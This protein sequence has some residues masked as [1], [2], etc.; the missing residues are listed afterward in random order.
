[1]TGLG[2][3]E[4][5]VVLM[6]E[7][8]SFDSMLGKLYPKSPA[9]DGLDGGESNRDATGNIIRVA[10]RPGTDP[11]AMSVPNP[12]PG[13]LWTDIN[14]QLF[15]NAVVPA[16]LPVAGMS[17][18]VQNYMAQEDVA[19]G[20]YDPN[21]V[22]NYYTPEQVPVIS[23]LARQFAVCDRWFASAPC[24]T[25]P[26]RFFAHTGTANGFENNDP[27]HFP[28]HMDTI[29]NRL[30]EAGME[31]PWKIYY[32]DYAQ[33]WSL[34]KLWLLM[35]HFHFYEQFQSDAKNGALPAYAFI[36]PRYYPHASQLP[37]DQHPPHVVTMGEQLIAD[38]YNCLRN[39]PQWQKTLLVIT[40][41]EHG[42]C[43]DHVPPPAAQPP[44]AQATAPF[45]FDRYGV[46]VPAVLVSPYIRQGT[47]LRPPGAVPFDHT[48][49]LST[50]R[51]CF[52]ELG[53]PLT[54]RDAVAPDLSSALTLAQ[55][56]NI[57]PSSLTAL[58]F[59]PTP[60]LVAR[61]QSAPPNGMQKALVKMAAHFPGAAPAD[62]TASFVA[63][64][65]ST[66]AGEA[67]PRAVPPGV[68]T[69]TAAGASAFIKSRVAPFISTF[70]TASS[71]IFPVI[72]DTK[73]TG[74]DGGLAVPVR[75]LA[76]GASAISISSL[77][78]A[79]PPA[80][81]QAGGVPRL[82]TFNANVLA[83]TAVPVMPPMT[84]NCDL[85][86][87][88]PTTHPIHWRL[89][90]LYVVGRYQKISP[91]PTPHYR[92]RVLSLPDEWTGT[93]RSSQFQLFAPD[94]NVTYDNRTDRVAG[95]DAMLTIA[96]QDPVSNQWLQDYVH[97][98][99]GGTNPGEANVRQYVAHILANRDA[100]ILH[101]ANAVF[102]HEDNMTQFDPR[103]RTNERYSGVVF[104]WP[105]DP[106][107][108]PSVAFD[109]GIGLGQFTHPGEETVSIC[110]DWRENLKA[111]VNE[112]LED[113][114][115]TFAANL[116]WR[117]WAKRAWSTYNAG[118]P[119]SAAGLAY[120]ATLQA[121][122]D[123]QLIATA[124]LPAGFDHIGQTAAIPM[125]P[126]P[127]PPTPW[128]VA[129]QV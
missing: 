115:S 4:H 108:F 110:W 35:D 2:P 53:A 104:N 3:I 83:I 77:D 97:I 87:V 64:H 17:G 76:V 126:F 10:N 95:G 68:D 121:L 32:H 5:V 116:T 96:V 89:Q 94:A 73:F 38:V 127:P 59:T 21:N 50:L 16:P 57:G 43:F 30:E 60:A 20:L 106:A 105:P 54:L 14:T 85:Q 27:P 34:A 113:L 123:G 46:R 93:S 124:N 31:N 40:Y 117:D 8:R 65:T 81:Y 56:V 71:T 112:L 80:P 111:G 119:T 84:V 61:A 48:S 6:L 37:N 72:D 90:T 102:T 98:R 47:V 125:A 41:D 75:R 62:D 79:D 18:F 100:N 129:V 45:N 36:E 58:P 11:A 9:F 33:T 42:G 7:N 103:F 26:N 23:R 29:F 39:S 91:A 92:S 49:I 63:N 101:M 12:D 114:R 107:N 55:P 86:G 52:P 120:A 22:M 99:I 28:Y 24:Q 19:A 88:D 69:S 118:S 78:R 66:L 128:P 15:G 122:P 25:W 1:M 13:E 67:A 51:A 82:A 70:S 109:Y 44:G 74:S